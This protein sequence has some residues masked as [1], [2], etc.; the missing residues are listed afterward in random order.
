MNADLIQD[1]EC[2]QIKVNTALLGQPPKYS[3]VPWYFS[4]LLTPSQ[5]HPIGKNVN[6]VLS[7]FV[8]SITLVSENDSRKSTVIL[9]SSAYA[10]SNQSPM[11]VNLSMI[12]APPER[13]VFNKQFI[14]TGILT[15]GKFTSVFNNRMV[16][17]FEIDARAPFISQSPA[18]KMIFISDGGL[19]ANKLSYK[20][21][22]YIP[23][24]LG[25]DKV[26]NITFGNKEF[27]V[28]AVHYLCDDSGLMN[29]RS[30]TMQMRLLDKVKL[31]E[32]KL[33]W[34]LF[35]VVFPVLMILI[36]GLIFW[37]LRHRKYARQHLDN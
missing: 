18:T 25:Y 5:N 8:S 13:K 37:L 28:N 35:N 32:Q 29:L 21:G 36:A 4:P 31:R 7:E 16:K 22:K 19:M 33:F 24:P 9:T 26:S 14:P 1:V 30:R 17:E 6:R 20:N 3:T 12:D 23:I 27:L 34:Q 2:Q 15:E 10:R 11:M